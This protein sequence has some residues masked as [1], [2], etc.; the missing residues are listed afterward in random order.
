MELK[1]GRGEEKRHENLKVSF[2]TYNRRRKEYRNHLIT[3]KTIS[4]L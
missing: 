3:T 2:K 4:P 1:L